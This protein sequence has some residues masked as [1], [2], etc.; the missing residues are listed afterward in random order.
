MAGAGGVTMRNGADVIVIG[1]GVIGAA[2]TFEM[3]RRGRSVVCVDAGS[4]VG[5]GSTSSSSAIIRFHYST[6]DGVLTA[7]ES[8]A[9][10]DRFG[11][12]LGIAGDVPVAKFIQTGCLVLDTPNSNRDA[13]LSLLARVGVP[14]EEWTAH[15]LRRRL[16]LLDIGDYWPPRRVDDADFTA[17]AHGELGGYY[18]PNAGFIDDPMLAAD[19]F[20][21]AARCHGATLRLNTRVCEIRERR[22]R[23]VG[24]TLASGERIDSDVVVNV[25]GPASSVIN[26]MAGVADEM[27]IGHRPLR[28]EV[29]VAKSPAG[30]SLG[31]G[32]TIVTDM[33]LGTYFRPHCA[34]TLLVGGTEPECDALQ[35]V[36]DPWDA[37]QLPTVDG[38]ETNMWR[39]ARRLPS[40]GIPNRPV[41]LAALYDASDD[42][43]PIYDGSSV[44]GF[45]MA[46]GTSGNQFKNAPLAGL[47]IA[48]LIEAAERG[49][50]H[51]I[52]PVEVVGP[53]TGLPI[54]LASFSRLRE[55][56][57]TSGTVM[58]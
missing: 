49:V 54:N 38:F 27:R 39:A 30:F 33:N 34:G 13:V 36:E 23:V 37:N 10:W 35:W 2:T 4:A 19:N 26:R 57:P 41:G 22:G 45:Y 9:I 50:E 52:D 14:Y 51:D 25:A 28:Q 44:E 11:D 8:A 21:T 40:L 55:K 6:W 42:W 20:M 29:S 46:C 15:D 12:Y 56:T 7:W 47:F 48:E 24:V 16:P 5:A 32:G 17:D 31:D 58:G 3:A 43:V 18:T 1:A 53:R